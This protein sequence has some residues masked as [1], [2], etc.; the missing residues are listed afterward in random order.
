MSMQIKFTNYKDGLHQFNFT[1]K[2][3]ELGVEE[4][5]IGNVLLNCEMDKSSSQIII[6]CNLG[7][8]AK[9][10]CDR[11]TAEIE[12]EFEVSFKSIYF[13]SHNKSDNEI[14][15]S[16]IHY[17]SPDDDKIDLSDDVI[18][19]ALLTIPMKVLCSENC[20]GLCPICGVNKNDKE[21]N[22]VADTSNPVWE[23]LLELKGKLN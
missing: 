4:K 13:I 20:K 8:T 7:I 17:L 22:C 15:E 11:C 19:N 1:T 3:E 10:E 18:E 16:G 12:D 2:V 21:C 9:L 23:K 6:N 14:D 5:F